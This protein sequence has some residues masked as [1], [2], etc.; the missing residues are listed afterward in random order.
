M[1]TDFDQRISQ[2]PKVLSK[3]DFHSSKKNVFLFFSGIGL[4]LL[5]LAIS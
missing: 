3:S 1:K 5:V 4:N 2:I